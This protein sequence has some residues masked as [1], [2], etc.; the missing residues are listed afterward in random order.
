MGRYLITG[1][2]GSG[3][4]TIAS[5]LQKQ[6][7][8][9][10]DGD[11]IPGLA[12]WVDLSTGQTTEV[13]HTGYVDYSK[14]GWNWSRDSLDALF[15]VHTDMILCGS[16][17]NQLDFHNRFDKVFVLALPEATQRQRILSRP[18]NGYGKHPATLKQ[19][20]QNQQ[21]F[22]VDALK[23]GAIPINAE[24]PVDL[25]VADIL[26]QVRGTHGNK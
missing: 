24:Q 21:T 13:D 12:R 6:N 2:S 4:S 7:Y 16:A 18:A 3:K 23:L 11:E 10:F 19:I 1:R 5:D 20:L 17:S 25:V 14:V 15:A 26:S 9:C 8:T 22:V